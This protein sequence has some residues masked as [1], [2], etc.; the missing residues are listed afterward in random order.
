MKK[1]WIWVIVA[2]SILVVVWATHRITGETDLSAKD[3]ETDSFFVALRKLGVST[4]P[5]WADEK[6]VLQGL[7]GVLVGVDI[8]NPEIEKYGL[9]KQ[10]LQTDT[11]LQLRQYGIKVLTEEELPSTPGMPCLFIQVNLATTEDQPVAGGSITVELQENVLLLREPKRVCISATTWSKSG[12]IV[13]GEGRIKDLRGMVKD[14]VNEFINDYLAANP[15]DHSTKKKGG[16]FDDLK[17]KD[18]TT[19]SSSF[20]DDLKKP[21][22]N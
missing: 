19:K 1:Y 20:L 16:V 21:K 10:A 18:G 17:Q 15:K 13:V 3:K 8:A 2:F 5:V 14:F 9:T 11:E 6:E 4:D 22:N 7:E 12:Q